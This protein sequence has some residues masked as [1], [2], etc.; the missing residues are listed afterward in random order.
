MEPNDL[1]TFIS[2]E[3]HVDPEKQPELVQIMRDAFGE[4]LLTE[5]VQHLGEEHVSPDDL[6]GRI[7]MMVSIGLLSS[8]THLTLSLQVEWYP[9]PGTAQ[10]T[11]IKTVEE[12]SS[13]SDDS[14]SDNSEVE[15]MKEFRKAHANHKAKISGELAQLGIYAN[16]IKPKDG[17]LER[18]RSTVMVYQDP[19]LISN[20]ELVEP[21]H[22][23]IN[24]SESALLGLL[25][26]KESAEKLIDHAHHY[27]RR[28]YPH[29]LRVNSTNVDPMPIWK[30]G[31]HVVGLNMQKWDKGTH[32]NG[33]LF[34]DT[35]GWVLK[36]ESLRGGP[37]RSG[38]A[39][40]KLNVIGGDDSKSIHCLFLGL[41]GSCSTSRKR[42]RR[43]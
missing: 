17:W 33:A 13:D 9:T 43:Q 41:I 29:G 14:D 19:S 36:P 30:C 28:C 38:T 12:E 16:S 26:Q 39:H 11:M 3:C 37:K 10:N 34:R 7:V 6:K 40:L 21:V 24:I 5:R 23:L 42:K 20:A 15:E 2:L 22:A 35:D 25:K 8:I 32:I 1:P 4:K 18:R 31:T 27:L